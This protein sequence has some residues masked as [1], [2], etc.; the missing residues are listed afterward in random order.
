MPIDYPLHEEMNIKYGRTHYVL[1]ILVLDFAIWLPM[2]FKEQFS[3]R[4][5]LFSHSIS[6]IFGNV[7]FRNS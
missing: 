1:F 3:L 2:A 4:N 6:V 5:E 7:I